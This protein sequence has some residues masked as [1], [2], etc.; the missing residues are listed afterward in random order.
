[1]R[2]IFLYLWKSLFLCMMEFRNASD[3]LG[4]LF[5][6]LY[7][8]TC[9]GKHLLCMAINLEWKRSKDSWVSEALQCRKREHWT[10]ITQITA[11]LYNG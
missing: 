6:Y 4:F 10:N 3:N 2:D 9:L 11:K 5:E 8:I 1:M 7:F